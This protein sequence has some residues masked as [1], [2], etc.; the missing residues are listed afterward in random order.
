L[1]LQQGSTTTANNTYNLNGGTLAISQ[2]TSVQTNGT[3]TFNFNGGTLKVASNANA[4]SF[5]NLGTGNARANVRNGGAII[6][7]NGINV[8]VAQALVHS[9]VSGDNATD[10]GLTKQGTGTLTLTAT[11]TYTGATTVNAGTILVSGSISGSTAT[12]NSSGTLGGAGGTTGAVIVNSGGTLSPGASIGTLNSISDVT[13]NAGSTFK[14]EI[15]TTAATTDVLAITG[16]LSLANTND[17]VLTISD[18]T[19]ATLSSGSLTFMTYTGTWNGGLFTYS[20]NVIADNGLLTVG[21]N[22]FTLDYNYNGNSVAL[23]IVPEPGAAASLFG[24]LG[25]LVGLQRFRRRHT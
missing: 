17:A 18:L 7:T 8:T 21:S 22:Q 25:L 12:V 15:D 9:N 4:A 11:N 13:L 23:I 20:G 24:S 16:N 19:P 6:D 1:D 10:G 3:R 2:V 5:F 14:L